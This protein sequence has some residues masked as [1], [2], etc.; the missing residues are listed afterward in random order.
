MGKVRR[1]LRLERRPA[2]RRDDLPHARARDAT[3]ELPRIRRRVRGDR[4]GVDNR[5]VRAFCRSDDLMSRRSELPGHLF[6]L[7]LVEAATDHIEINFHCGIDLRLQNDEFVEDHVHIGFIEDPG[8]H[9]HLSA[10]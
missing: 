6:D 4:A 8:D 1:F 2:P 9:A 5:Q 7:R 10:G 3:D